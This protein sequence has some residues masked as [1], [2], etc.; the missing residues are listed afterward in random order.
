M[1]PDHVQ[2]LADSFHEESEECGSSV[3]AD[4][5]ERRARYSGR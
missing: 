4:F 2:W 3:M 1:T 5:I